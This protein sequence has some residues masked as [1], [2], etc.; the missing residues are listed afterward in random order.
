MHPPRLT[1]NLPMGKSQLLLEVLKQD[2]SNWSAYQARICDG[3]DSEGLRFLL[4]SS[5]S[6]AVLYNTEA[7]GISDMLATM[8]KSGA[9][10]DSCSKATYKV[11][12]FMNMLNLCPINLSSHALIFKANQLLGQAKFVILSTLNQGIVGS[13]P[14]LEDGSLD[15]ISS[16]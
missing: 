16:I 14:R 4:P 10:L 9:N 1:V 13:L 3:F 12:K 6:E 5:T 8:K 15:S 7:Y 11:L 2:G